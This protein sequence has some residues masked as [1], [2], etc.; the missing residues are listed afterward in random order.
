MWSSARDKAEKRKQLC[1]SATVSS[2]C[3][4]QHDRGQKDRN[5]VLQENGSEQGGKIISTR[6][7][8]TDTDNRANANYRLRLVARETKKGKRQD[9]FL[10][11][12]PLADCAKGQRQAKPLRIGIFHVSRAYFHAPAT[13][14]EDWEEG[15]EGLV[16]QLQI[17]LYGR[18]DAAQHWA[19]TCTKFLV[20][21]GFQRGR[22]SN[23]NFVH[24]RRNI[25]MTAHGEDFLAADL[26]Q[27]KW[28]E[29]QLKSEYTVKAEV[30]GLELELRK[31]IKILNRSIRW[32]HAEVIIEE[33]EARWMEGWNR[34]ERSRKD[35]V[36]WSCTEDQLPCHG[37]Q[38]PSVCGKGI[39]LQDGQTRPQELG[40]SQK[41]REAPEISTPR[42]L[43]VPI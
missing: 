27:M 25:K 5:G 34:D 40:Q 33:C 18:R 38:R 39:L 37:P 9:L 13:P 43:G 17:S 2:L 6:W 3:T 41:H 10:A 4:D 32:W 30:L 22:A 8:D 14:D 28:I 26:D 16:G 42:S 29:E 24:K 35:E 11:T 31:E 21:I 15:D 7:V 1:R 36:P 19:A 23:C 12:P 20:K